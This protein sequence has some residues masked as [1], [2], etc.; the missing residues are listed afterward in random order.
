MR[1]PGGALFELAVTHNE[2]GWDCDESPEELGRAFMLPP[3]FEHEREHIMS[4][5]EPLSVD[6]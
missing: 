1:T 2:G 4:Q 6:D 5:L 3:Q